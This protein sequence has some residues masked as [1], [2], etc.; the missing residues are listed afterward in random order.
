MLSCSGHDRDYLKESYGE[1]C[2]NVPVMTLEEV[3]MPLIAGPGEGEVLPTVTL[4]LLQ[5]H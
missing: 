2:C 4:P 3:R 5:H 1:E